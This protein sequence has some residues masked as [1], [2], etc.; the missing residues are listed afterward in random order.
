MQTA[1]LPL[2]ALAAGFLDNPLRY[3]VDE[4][5]PNAGIRRDFLDTQGDFL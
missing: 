3:Q 2:A 1:S 4:E 5:G